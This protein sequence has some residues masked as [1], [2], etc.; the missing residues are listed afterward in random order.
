MIYICNQAIIHHYIYHT[1]LSQ[2]NEQAHTT[3]EKV[4]EANH[5][6]FYAT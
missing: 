1:A 6:E 4:N 5:K 2:T 3:P